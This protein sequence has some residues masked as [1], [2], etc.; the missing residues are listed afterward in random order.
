M[1]RNKEYRVLLGGMLIVALIN[2]IGAFILNT[3][4]GFLA[5]GTSILLLILIWIFNRRRYKKLDE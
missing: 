1:I 4:A 5:L 2:I 3:S